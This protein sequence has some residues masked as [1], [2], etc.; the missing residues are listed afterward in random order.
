MDHDLHGGS[1][2]RHLG[3]LLALIYCKL[4]VLKYLY[5]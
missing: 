1:G 3:S 5:L 4:F 2:T